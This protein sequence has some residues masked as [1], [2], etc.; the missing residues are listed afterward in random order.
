MPDWERLADIL[1]NSSL[2]REAKLMIIDLLSLSDDQ[3]LEE[4]I[5]ELVFKWHDA[6]KAIVDTLLDKFDEVQQ[7]FDDEK[8]VI[9]KA[10][11]HETRKVADDVGR[12]QRIQQ[13]R[14]HIETL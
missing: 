6:D 14:E 2:D 5:S 9:D 3:E 13:I 12:Q 1:K 8:E 10:I 11:T 7:R 4:H